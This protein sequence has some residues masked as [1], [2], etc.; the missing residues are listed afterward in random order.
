[1]FTDNTGYF[2]VGILIASITI[3]MLFEL[4]ED[5]FEDGTF[6]HSFGQYAGAFAAGFFGGLSG[7]ALALIGW[8]MVGGAADYM[9]SG[10]FNDDTFLKDI[11]VIGVTSV[12]SVGAGYGSKRVVSCFKASSILKLQTNNLSNRALSNIGM[13]AVK[14]G[15]KGVKETLGKIIYQSG[16][17]FAGE[18]VQAVSTSVASNSIDDGLYWIFD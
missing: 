3:A 5:Y 13:T 10:N 7:G 15:K 6:N 4:G 18:M 8:S 1:M 17:Y 11:V 9:L 12:L 2:V 16:N 14:V